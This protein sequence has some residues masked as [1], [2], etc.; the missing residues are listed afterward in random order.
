MHMEKAYKD[1]AP[2]LRG[3]R[4]AL[5]MSLEDMAAKTGVSAVLGPAYSGRSGSVPESSLLCGAARVPGG[6]AS[7][8]NP[9]PRERSTN[10]S[11][12]SATLTESGTVTG[13]GVITSRTRMP[14]SAC[15]RIS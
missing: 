1:I 10:S 3:L 13:S 4:D 8:G 12:S 11:T 2:R 7:S 6:K 9:E 5:D 15:S 14:P